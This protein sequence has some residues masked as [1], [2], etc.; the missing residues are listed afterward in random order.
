MQ[1][2]LDKSKINKHK[3]K[4]DLSKIIAFNLGQLVEPCFKP[5]LKKYYYEMLKISNLTEKDLKDFTKEY[6]KGRKESKFLLHN[7]RIS[8]FYIFIMHCLSQEK[9]QII[10]KYMMIFYTIR[11]YRALM[12]KYFPNFCDK[13]LFRYTLETINK[14]HLFSREKTI[15]SALFHIS[16]EMIRR[17]SN[18]IKD[19]DKDKISKF[20]QESRHRIEQSVR[21]FAESYYRNSKEGAL[22]KTELE[23][24]DNEENIYQYQ[25]TEK[26]TRLVNDVVRKITVYRYVDHK[27]QEEARN[28][29]RIKS[30]LATI[31]TNNLN[32]TKFSD[33]LKIILN[34]FMKDVRNVDMICGKGFYT[35][36]KKLMSVKRTTSKTYFKQQVNIL[37]LKV[38]DESK[39][40]KNYDSLSSQT[41]FLVA[42]FLGHYLTMVVRNS[43]C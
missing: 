21:S 20:I 31:I 41:Q 30:S 4:S 28:I 10:F 18:S 2:L 8:M 26:S 1:K 9:N 5:S 34:L 38:L 17:Y 27:A 16:N 43:I 36:V 12:D 24:Q 33:D 25:S 22:I 15:P 14:T 13:D 23:P 6:W 40:R 3:L 7:D 29:S 19:N 39:Y 11:Y 37:L 32:N 42:S 35:Y